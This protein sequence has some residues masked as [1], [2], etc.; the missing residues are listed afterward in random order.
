M[1]KT[2]LWV[3]L[4]VTCFASLQFNN[5]SSVRG[6]AVLLPKSDNQSF[7]AQFNNDV[8]A[9]SGALFNVA[10]ADGSSGVWRAW[11]NQAWAGYSAGAA[12]FGFFSNSLAGYYATAAGYFV[13]GIPY[14]IVVTHSKARGSGDY[15]RMWVNG[16]RVSFTQQAADGNDT[17]ASDCVWVGNNENNIWLDNKVDMAAYWNTITLTDEMAQDLS[18]LSVDP[19][20]AMSMNPE[21]YY[22]FRIKDAGKVFG[23]AK[24]EGNKGSGYDLYQVQGTTYHAGNTN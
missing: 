3:V 16:V 6:T 11:I 4:S 24:N 21:V 7:M 19:Q 12:M 15:M 1:I 10:K 8:N 23:L 9:T 20:S 22:D 17:G 2:L 5:N 13:P 14:R 18:N